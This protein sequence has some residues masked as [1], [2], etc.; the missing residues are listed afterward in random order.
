MARAYVKGSIFDNDEDYTGNIDYAV[1]RLPSYKIP[2]RPRG[3]NSP[4]L[5]PLDY[6]KSS[7]DVIYEDC[8]WPY[9]RK[10]I[11]KDGVKA[12]EHPV[13]SRIS[14][15][16]PKLKPEQNAQ[17]IPIC[18]SRL[19]HRFEQAQKVTF[20]SGDSQYSGRGLF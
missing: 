12:A 11:K 15:A 4:P 10:P 2:P 14:T 8:C 1:L 17:P 6:P 18:I 7:N 9:P 3:P 20:S 19:Q 5:A 16:G 13:V